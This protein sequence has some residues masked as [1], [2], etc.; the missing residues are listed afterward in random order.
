MGHS[1][2]KSCSSVEAPPAPPY[3][4]FVRIYTSHYPLA[5]GHHHKRDLHGKLLL[6][7]TRAF[8]ARSIH[9]DPTDGT[10]WTCST[11]DVIFNVY[12]Q[13]SA[14]VVISQ[15]GMNEPRKWFDGV[16][17]DP[18]DGSLWSCSD[19]A[20]VEYLNHIERALDGGGKHPLIAEFNVSA[21]V[22]V[23]KDL[24]FD[25]EDN[26]IWLLDS[27]N[28]S[29]VHVDPDTGLELPGKIDLVACGLPAAVVYNGL[30][31]CHPSR[32]FFVARELGP[33]YEIRKPGILYRTL[34]LQDNPTSVTG[35]TLSP[36]L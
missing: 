30:E 35:V 22:G 25:V 5:S 7:F 15:G 21:F 2:G 28:F 36:S 19:Y 26:T 13:G 1:R 32:S 18:R 14:V 34:T 16:M 8:A 12:H 29:L 24:C 33:I 10:F 31:Y 4:D 20:G 3:G 27:P 23:N 9:Y 11:A 17:V 6:T